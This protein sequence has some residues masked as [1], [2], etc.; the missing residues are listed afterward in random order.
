[1]SYANPYSA[2]AHDHP[3]ALTT[4]LKTITH[5]TGTVVYK[6]ICI[7]PLLIDGIHIHI[8]KTKTY[9]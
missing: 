3:G 5:P 9:Y 2:S 7:C 1:M 6:N 8:D 4:Q